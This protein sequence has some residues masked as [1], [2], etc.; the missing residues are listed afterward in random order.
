MASILSRRVSKLEGGNGSTPPPGALAGDWAQYQ[1]WDLM[2]DYPLISRYCSLE[3]FLIGRACW[4]A[5]LCSRSVAGYNFWQNYREP[6]WF[7]NSIYLSKPGSREFVAKERAGYPPAGAL[8]SYASFLGWRYG[9]GVPWQES[10]DPRHHDLMAA[11]G[12]WLIDVLGLSPAQVIENYLTHWRAFSIGGLGSLADVTM[13]ASFIRDTPA[14]PVPAV[15]ESAAKFG[16]SDYIPWG[17]GLPYPDED[18]HLM[19]MMMAASSGIT[20]G[21]GG[22]YPAVGG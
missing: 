20:E 9:L 17:S 13:P 19:D 18:L 11:A 1:D 7:T 21:N 6:S 10:L 2:Q 8:D 15:A 12:I 3:Q 16:V 22:L 14:L 4:L 5:R